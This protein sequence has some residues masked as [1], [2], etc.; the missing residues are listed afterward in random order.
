MRA[1]A[2]GPEGATSKTSTKRDRTMRCGTGPRWRSTASR[3]RTLRSLTGRHRP[4]GLAHARQAILIDVTKMTRGRVA[5]ACAA[6]GETGT[7]GGLRGRRAL[8]DGQACSPA[9]AAAEADSADPAT[10]IPGAIRAPPAIADAYRSQVGGTGGSIAT[11]LSG[12]DGVHVIV[13]VAG[14]SHGL[15]AALAGID[16]RHAIA[17]GGTGAWC[18]TAQHAVAGG[19]AACPGASTSG[20]EQQQQS[21][22]SPLGLRFHVFS[23]W[24]LLRATARR[25]RGAAE[26]GHP[27]KSCLTASAPSDVFVSGILPHPNPVGVRPSSSP[28]TANQ[29]RKIGVDEVAVALFQPVGVARSK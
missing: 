8:A 18:L 25:D 2:L 4:V 23:L 12:R 16:R 3:A 11:T 14:A 21:W 13:R 26:F 9:E 17:A 20:H 27:A 28:L 19:I 7:A 22:K 5:D 10:G 15:A 1:C 29:C 24:Q 6:G